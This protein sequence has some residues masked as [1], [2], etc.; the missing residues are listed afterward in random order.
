MIKEKL[1]MDLFCYPI[2]KFILN[3]KL[4]I[5]EKLFVICQNYKNVVTNLHQ[6]KI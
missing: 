5:R 4:K 2:V 1:K 6:N 3:T